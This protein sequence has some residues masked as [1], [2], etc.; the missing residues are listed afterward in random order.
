M[1]ARIDKEGFVLE[2][3]ERSSAVPEN[4][5]E[6]QI[7]EEETEKIRRGLADGKLVAL[8]P[9]LRY[10]GIGTGEYSINYIERVQ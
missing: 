5:S 6:C 3:R 10:D 7:G 2:L 9:I 1:F 8:S 4:V